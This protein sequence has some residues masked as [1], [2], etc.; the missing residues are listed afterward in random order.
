[1]AAV[2]ASFESDADSEPRVKSTMFPSIIE[3]TTPQ[4]RAAV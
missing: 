1:M 3:S 4:D 2:I